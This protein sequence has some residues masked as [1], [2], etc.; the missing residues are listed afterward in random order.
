MKPHAGAYAERS[1]GAWGER[2]RPRICLAERLLIL[3]VVNSGIIE[4]EGKV[5]LSSLSLVKRVRHFTDFDMF[6][7]Q[8]CRV[9]TLK[10]RT[11][12]MIGRG[13]LMRQKQ[14]GM[15]NIKKRLQYNCIKVVSQCYPTHE[16]SRITEP[17]GTS[18]KLELNGQTG[19]YSNNLARDTRS[20]TALFALS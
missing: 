20:L 7:M 8:Q 4:G 19:F 5:H 18:P 1:C 2:R 3:E 13:S 14:I 11:P 6:Q 10:K 12:V 16:S 9:R 15:D 17:Q